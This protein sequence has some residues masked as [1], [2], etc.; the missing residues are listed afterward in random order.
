MSTKR[1]QIL[2]IYKEMAGQEPIE[3]RAK[4]FRA[5]FIQTIQERV[6]GLDHAASGT[7]GM[8]YAWSKFKIDNDGVARKY[9]SEK[10]VKGKAKEEQE[11]EDARK[12]FLD[13]VPESTGWKKV[14]EVLN[15]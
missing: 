10:R 8:Y 15:A 6:E 3:T 9:H 13:P 14:E 11:V 1:D 5:R 4:D 12:A 2:A 7:L